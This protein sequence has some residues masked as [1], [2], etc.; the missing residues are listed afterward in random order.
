MRGK[1][2][3][4]RSKW[5]AQHVQCYS[6]RRVDRVK[7]T[8]YS[9]WYI[10]QGQPASL[11]HYILLLTDTTKTLGQPLITDYIR[12]M[13]HE[14]KHMYLSMKGIEG[15]LWLW[16]FAR[17]VYKFKEACKWVC[18]TAQQKIA[19]LKTSCLPTKTQYVAST[20]GRRMG[21]RWMP[22]LTPNIFAIGWY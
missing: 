20:K 6:W 2:Q 17:H 9:C 13:L 14:S 22:F 5:D 4:S 10:W 19:M 15:N 7:H 12:A 16:P 11:A 21:K 18:W 1:A 8:H 3:R